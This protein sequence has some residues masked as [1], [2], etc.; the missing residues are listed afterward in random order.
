MLKFSYKLIRVLILG[1]GVCLTGVAQVQVSPDWSSYELLDKGLAVSFP[2][3]PMILERSDV[4]SHRATRSYFAYAHGAVY[5]AS[6]V[7]RQDGSDRYCKV[8]QEFNDRSFGERLNE[9]SKG[10]TASETQVNGVLVTRFTSPRVSAVLINNG[11]NKR[12]IELWIRS[13]DPLLLD[14]AAWAA[15]LVIGSKSTAGVLGAGSQFIAGDTEPMNAP[16]FSG[17]QLKDIPNASPLIIAAKPKPIFTALARAHNTAG[18]VLLQVE[19]LATGAIGRIEVVKDLKDGL[20]EAAVAAAKKMVFV[21]EL[22]DGR[23][24]TTIRKVEYAFA[25]Y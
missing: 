1:A 24:V 3:V 6:I 25:I 9:L 22:S 13:H 4:C 11:G 23:P 21:P 18:T 17:A 7:T 14:A 15:S 20:S 12:W 8:I 19:F 10:A 2:K 5:E 16:T